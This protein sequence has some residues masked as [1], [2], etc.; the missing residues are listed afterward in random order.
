MTSGTG[1]EDESSFAGRYGRMNDGEL[2]KIAAGYDSLVEPA[3]DALRAEFDQ[4]K[5]EPPLVEDDA[6]ALD[7]ETLVTVRRYRD[8]SEAIVARTVLESAGIYCFLR[9]ENLVRLDWQV[10]N[11]IGG[12][13][14][15]VRPEDEA[16]AVELLN[17]P[18]PESIPFDG[19]GDY[20]QPVCPHCGSTNITFEGSDRKAAITSLFV[21]GLPLPPG[22]T[23][24]RCEVCGSR[25]TGD[26]EATA[27]E[28]G[29]RAET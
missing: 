10:S 7:S 25:W 28:V 19:R 18:V 12:L 2:L 16:A 4:R 20:A 23:S 11:A 24:W 15:Q 17:Q 8:L 29:G 5:M 9:D 21:L 3:K 27:S 6:H 1:S 26:A 14:L 13:S 22:R